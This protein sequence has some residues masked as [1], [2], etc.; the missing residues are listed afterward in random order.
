MIATGM[1]FTQACPSYAAWNFSGLFKK[2]IKSNGSVEQ[3]YSE[4]TDSL[5]DKI[6]SNNDTTNI[7]VEKTQH[8]E[9]AI[10]IESIEISGNNLVGSEEILR[11][12]KIQAGDPYSVDI[13]QQNLKS[14]YD[15]GY[16]TEK[17]KA[18]P[19]KIDDKNVKLKIVVQENVPITD[20]TI[21]GN[22]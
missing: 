9:S 14:I 1:V 20:F 16:F 7:Q 5:I 15:M 2:N 3:P 19:I 13:V 12:M 18:I 8:D 22:K 6:N 11:Y 4:T 10:K 21:T 17:M